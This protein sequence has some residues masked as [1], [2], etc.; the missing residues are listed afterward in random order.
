MKSLL[1]VM[2]VFS[3]FIDLALL[4]AGSHGKLII[5]D[6]ESATTTLGPIIFLLSAISLGLSLKKSDSKTASNL[7][8]TLIFISVIFLISHLYFIFTF[9]SKGGTIPIIIP[10][11]L[12]VQIIISIIVIGKE[13]IIRS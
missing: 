11:I 12:L 8:I 7:S 4:G 10:I 1:I 2:F 5:K 9:N 3:A 13:R 6:L